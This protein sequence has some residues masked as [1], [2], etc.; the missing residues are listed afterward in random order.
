MTKSGRSQSMATFPVPTLCQ[1]PS[2]SLAQ[3]YT[4]LAGVPR[5]SLHERHASWNPQIPE[6]IRKELPTQGGCLSGLWA[7]LAFWQG[8]CHFTLVTIETRLCGQNRH[9]TKPCPRVKSKLVASTSYTR[10][11]DDRQKAP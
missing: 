8:R 2:H 5:V 11:G 10:H 1:M 6:G 7:I 4:R 9:A 3:S